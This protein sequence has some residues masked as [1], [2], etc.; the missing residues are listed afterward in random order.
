[1]QLAVS[2]DASPAPTPI[3]FEDFWALYPR[4]M[5][6]ADARKAWAKLPPQLYAEVL[7]A[8][9]GWR[10]VWLERG[11]LQFVPYPATWL[12]GERWTDELPTPVAAKPLCAAHVPAPV[13][14]GTVNKG[15]PP[16]VAALVAKMRGTR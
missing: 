8:L 4:K 10:R 15:L 16:E 7:T 6:K 14:G 9:A 5:A 12:N 2:N 11:E 1:M 13:N 3:T